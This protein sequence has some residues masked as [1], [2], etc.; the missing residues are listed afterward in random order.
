MVLSDKEL[1][2]INKKAVEQGFNV[3]PRLNYNTVS[4]V[5]GPLE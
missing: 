2:A 1:F 3:K 5:N 4:G